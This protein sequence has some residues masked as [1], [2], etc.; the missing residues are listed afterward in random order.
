MSSNESSLALTSYWSKILD[1]VDAAPAAQPLPAPLPMPS[2]PTVPTRC[3][4]CGARGQTLHEPCAY[5]NQQ[6]GP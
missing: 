4:E 1:D 5:C 3:A 2:D 6:V